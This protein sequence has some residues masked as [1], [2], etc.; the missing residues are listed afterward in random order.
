[1]RQTRTAARFRIRP[2]HE[3]DEAGV[4]ELMRLVLGRGPV[5]HRPPEFFRWKHLANPFGRSLLLVAEADGSVVGLRAF[6]RWRFQAGEHLVESVRAVDTATHPDYRRLGVFAELTAEA[7]ERVEGSVDLVYNLPNPT[8]F[9]QYARLG[10]QLAGTVPRNLRVRRPFGFARGL[11]SLRSFDGPSSARPHV[12]AESAALALQDGA[13]ISKLLGRAE[14]GG[15]RLATPRTLD[16]LRWRYAAAP[17][18]DYRAILE[19]NSGS[20]PSG[21]AIFRIRPRGRLWESSLV[22]LITSPGDASTA[23]RLIRRVVRAAAVHHLTCSFPAGSTASRAAQRCAF[24]HAP[25][26]PLAVRPLAA[27]LAPDPRELGTWALSLGDI[28]VF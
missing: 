15:Q 6:M 2:F 21:L 10:W 19:R 25:G 27:G 20:E 17:F 1:M 16:Y 23:R 14:T 3:E 18:L 12:E 28:E 24:L 4:L 7:L 5:P 26:F 11:R 13:A 9:R 22:E 8:S